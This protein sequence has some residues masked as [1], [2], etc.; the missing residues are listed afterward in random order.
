MKV[1]GKLF[2]AMAAIMT[3]PSAADAAVVVDVNQVGS[4][5]VATTSGSLNL[6]GL[7]NVG[8]FAL[9]LSLRPTVGYVASGGTANAAV[10][11]YSGL[12]GPTAFGTGGFTFATSGTGVSFAINAAAFGTP[13][14]FVP[15]GY[16]SGS[17]LAGTALF[18]GRTFANLGLTAGTYVF[19]TAADTVTVN[20]GAVPETASWIMM[21]L[22]IG[23]I[24][25]AMRRSNARFDAKIKRITAGADD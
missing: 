17:S 12:T 25:F 8:N 16:A 7:V 22:G 15:T 10:V 13:Y 20:I 23:A 18:A 5:V 2:A 9:G 11:G 3:L 24:G 4:N 6:A 19:R 1:L 21:I 14:V